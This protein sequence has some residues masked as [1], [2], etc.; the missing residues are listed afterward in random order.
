MG[1]PKGCESCFY[2]KKEESEFPCVV[3]KGYDYY[4]HKDIYKEETDNKAWARVVEGLNG[5]APG[6][7]KE[8]K[9]GPHFYAGSYQLWPNF[10]GPIVGF[11][12]YDTVNKP[13]HYMLFDQGDVTGYAYVGKG[14]EV[15]D[16]IVKLVDKIS[17]RVR[18]G[19]WEYSPMFESDYVQMMQ[20]GMRFMDKNGVEDLKKMRWYL[21]KLIEAY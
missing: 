20:Y 10:E 18:N 4:L 14:I 8:V 19:D 12:D 16:V 5:T 6:D 11:N 2:A 9:G 7:F 13:K 17:F 3:C 21:D 1:K 15:R